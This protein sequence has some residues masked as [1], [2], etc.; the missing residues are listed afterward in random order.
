EDL[1]EAVAMATG[2]DLLNTGRMYERPLRVAYW[3]GEDPQEEVERRLEA[4]I[5]HYSVPEFPD[6]GGSDKSVCQHEMPL[7]P[8][9]LELL[10]N[11]LFTDTGRKKP[12]KLAS[13]QHSTF[14]MW[15]PLVE[16]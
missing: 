1:V 8:A 14:K 5:R 12:I 4:V 16:S 3:N 11:N 7:Q 15:T 13:E 2:V 10:A 9:H 6:G